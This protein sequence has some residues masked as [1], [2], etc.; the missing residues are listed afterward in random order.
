MKQVTMAL[1]AYQT[2]CYMIWA[3]ESNKCVVIDPGYDADTVLDQAKEQGK[4][5]EAILAVREEK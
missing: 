1:G 2:N 3:E 5:I 4:T